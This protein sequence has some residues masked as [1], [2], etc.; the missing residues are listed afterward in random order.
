MQKIKTT[1]TTTKKTLTLAPALFF[2]FLMKRMLFETF[3]P[4]LSTF[5]YI[6]FMHEMQ[7][8]PIAMK[9]GGVLPVSQNPALTPF[10]PHI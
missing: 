10:F 8:S 5:P 2:F 3:P 9:M 1:K 7:I 6:I 4:A